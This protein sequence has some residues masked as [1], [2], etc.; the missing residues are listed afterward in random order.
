MLVARLDAQATRSSFIRF[1][2]A[3]PNER[4]QALLKYAPEHRRVGTLR[5]DDR[6]LHSGVDRANEV[7]GPGCGCRRAPGLPADEVEVDV[8]PPDRER[9]RNG[10]PVVNRDRGARPDLEAVRAE[11]SAM[12]RERARERRGLIRSTA[13]ARSAAG[14][15]R[16]REHHDDREQTRSSPIPSTVPRKHRKRSYLRRGT[17]RGR[18]A[19]CKGAWT[20]KGRRGCSIGSV[21]PTGTFWTGT[22]ASCGRCSRDTAVSKS[23]WRAI[24]SSSRSPRR[25]TVARAI[26]EMCVGLLRTPP[27]PP[28]GCRDAAHPRPCEPLAETARWPRRRP[29]PPDR[30]PR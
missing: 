26:V 3:M 9:V 1:Q 5:N 25:P 2:A 17:Y 27:A 15:A 29:Q 7:V 16:E 22:D 4:W 13:A 30:S 10:V 12:H 11:R 28:P 8:G 18:A 14:H 20:S 23:A 6:A 21:T 24:R 19:V